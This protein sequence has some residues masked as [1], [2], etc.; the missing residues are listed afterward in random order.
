MLIATM[1]SPNNR[2]VMVRMPVDNWEHA[3]AEAKMRGLVLDGVDLYD[4]E[5]DS[6]GPYGEDE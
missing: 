4:P 5:S 1:S 3:E 6:D 2:N